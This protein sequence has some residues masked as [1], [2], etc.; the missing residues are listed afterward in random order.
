MADAPTTAPPRTGRRRW[1]LPAIGV[2]LA[3]F[4]GIAA[5]LGVRAWLAKGELEKV[6][7]ERTTL[8]TAIGTR[9][10][11][12]AQTALDDVHAHAARAAELTSDPLWRAAEVL[13]FAGPNAAAVRVSAESVRDLTAAADPLLEAMHAGTG[14]EPGVD[15]ARIQGLTAPL[16]QTADATAHAQAELDRIDPGALLPPMREGVTDIRAFVTDA[17]PLLDDAASAASILPAMLGADG[18]RTLLVMVQNA[19][20]ARTGGGITGSFIEVRA[21][22]GKLSVGAHADSASFARSAPPAMELPTELT[23]L[24]GPTF[25]RYVTNITVTPDFDL[26]ARLASAWWQTLAQPAPDAIVSI[27]PI[28]LRALLRIT[29]PLTLSDGSVVDTASVI[30]Q[31]LVRPYLERTPLEQTAM[32]SDLTQHLFET[33]L[34]TPFDVAAWAQALAEPVAQGRVSVWSAHADEQAVLAEGPLAGTL[35]RYRAAGDDAIGVYFND[36]TTGKLDTFLYVQV[37]P[38]TRVC[39]ADGVAEVEV[40]VTLQSTLTDAARTYPPSMTGATNPGA[41]GD[42]TT[43]VTVMVPSGWYFGGVESGGAAVVSTDVP[44]ANPA[45]VVRIALTPGQSQTTTFR[46]LAGKDG[47]ATHPVIVHTPM[48][49]PVTVAPVAAAPCD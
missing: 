6:Q 32:Q 43:D 12:A 22:D 13:P 8:T 46:F 20:E 2:V 29:G 1:L 27:D 47:Q 49:N 11:P 9:D 33:L 30:E 19:A 31:M 3:L 25:G 45:S 39:R 21:T 48:M 7:A 44:G 37:D 16:R 24:Y 34:D 35:A 23:A 18:D 28:V 41:P 36:A 40:A 5:W 26:S 42:I 17:A 38:S 4:V 14:T 10:M 15:L